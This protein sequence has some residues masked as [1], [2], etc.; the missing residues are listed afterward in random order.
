MFRHNLYVNFVWAFLVFFMPRHS[1][2]ADDVITNFA[3]SLSGGIGLTA[4]TTTVLILLLVAI[5]LESALAILFNWRPFVEIFNARAVRPLIA[6]GVSLVFVISY[7]FDAVSAL[8]SAVTQTNSVG[9]PLGKILTAA[10][11]AGGSAGINTLLVALGFREVKT[12]TTAGPRPNPNEAWVAL[13]IL[14]ESDLTDDV[15]VHI[16]PFIPDAPNDVTK[17]PL[18]AVLPASHMK[19]R[20]AIWRFFFSETNRFP[21][22]GGHSVP[23]GERCQIAIVANSSQ[24]EKGTSRAIFPIPEGFLPAPGAII[25]FSIQ[26]TKNPSS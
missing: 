25:D 4:A 10:I 17:I 11:L 7:Q 18:V 19:E 26:I 23:L 6:F 5:L 13:K 14:P 24:S 22:Y 20:T 8:M 3:R 16:G 15:R 1:Y 2:A 21:S 9:L 12:P